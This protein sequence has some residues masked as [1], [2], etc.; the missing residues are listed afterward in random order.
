MPELPDVHILNGK[1]FFCSVYMEV[2]TNLLNISFTEKVTARYPRYRPWS[3]HL[4]AGQCTG[5][6][7]TSNSGA[8]S[9]WEILRSSRHA[10]AQQPGH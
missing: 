1:N 9:S 6:S 2:I 10:A 7:C 3:S 8:A 5:S 4:S